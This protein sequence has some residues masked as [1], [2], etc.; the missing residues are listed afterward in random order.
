M[1]ILGGG[2]AKTGGESYENM[3]DSNRGAFVTP[4]ACSDPQRRLKG[5]LLSMDRHDE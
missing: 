5:Y 4:S 2:H 3:T 1:I